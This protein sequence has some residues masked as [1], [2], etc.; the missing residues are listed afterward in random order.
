MWPWRYLLSSELSFISYFCLRYFG[1]CFQW[2]TSN[3]ITKKRNPHLT[4]GQSWL[5]PLASKQ[6]SN[7]SGNSIP[8][9]T[10]GQS[11]L[12]S[13]PSPPISLT[14]ASLLP[15]TDGPLCDLDAT[16]H[17][18]TEALLVTFASKTLWVFCFFNGILQISLQRKGRATAESIEEQHS[19]QNR[20]N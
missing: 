14:L 20:T 2:N 9:L 17:P 11:W 1:F 18:L 16:S 12:S 7:S 4:S 15:N 10:F 19:H 3:F 13:G 5:Y 6:S 8:H